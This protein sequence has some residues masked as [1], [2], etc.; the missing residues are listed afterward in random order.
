MVQNIRDML[1]LRWRTAQLLRAVADGTPEEVQAIRAAM[2]IAGISESD[3]ADELRLLLH[4]F[5][6]RPTFYLT[7]EVN[8]LWRMIRSTCVRCGRR[9][10]Y[11]DNDYVC[12]ECI[13]KE[14]DG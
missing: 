3:R 7:E 10:P 12:A 8:R 1:H 13:L 9:S 14:D 5:G 4:Q 2:R 11:L 6:H